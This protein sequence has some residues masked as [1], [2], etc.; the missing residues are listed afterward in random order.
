MCGFRPLRLPQSFSVTIAVGSHPFPSRTR[1]LS[2]P[3]PMVLRWKRLGRVGRRRIFSYSY[4]H[5]K[6]Q[7]TDIQTEQP[8]EK[9]KATKSPDELPY[10][11]AHSIVILIRRI[12][13]AVVSIVFTIFFIW[14]NFWGK[15]QIETRYGY[16]N[17][18]TTT[19]TST[20]TTS[21]SFTTTSTTLI[22]EGNFPSF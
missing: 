17:S 9:E 2:P 12:A 21:S 14:F 7:M 8:S 6:I 11:K 16:D 18:T 22:N 1:Q 19:S 10:A 4:G 5:P 13:S 3:A 15:D 20:T